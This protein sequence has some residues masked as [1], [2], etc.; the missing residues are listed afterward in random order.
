MSMT[1]QDAHISRFD[2]A[3]CRRVMAMVRSDF[4]LEP[5]PTPGEGQDGFFEVTL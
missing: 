4:G 3:Q 5:E 1:Q 2:A